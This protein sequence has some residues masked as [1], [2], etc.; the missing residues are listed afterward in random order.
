MLRA[1]VFDFD[2]VI[3]NSEPLHFRAYRE[4][5]AGV[6]ITLTERDYYD[7]YLGFDE[8][9]AFEQ[10]ARDYGVALTTG[11]L[12]ELVERKAARLEDLEAGVSVLFAGAA[13]AIRRAAAAVP[14]G[15]ASGARGEEIRRVLVREQLATSF[16]A[17]VAA[18]D[19]PISKPAPDPYL[20]VLTRLRIATGRSI[21]ARECVAVEDSRWGLQSARAAGMRT[22]AVTH[23]YDKSELEDAADLVIQS[24]PAMDLDAL[25]ALCPESN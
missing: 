3:A 8:V 6:A 22:V 11:Q 25:A 20:L 13:D 9:A 18:E 14:I 1:I 21:A 17:I 12:R 16:T 7:R 19:T 5:L 2:G 4:V 23:T 10:I 15:I 24:L